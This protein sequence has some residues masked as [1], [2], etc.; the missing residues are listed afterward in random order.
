MND[1]VN[2]KDENSP[3][4]RPRP[5]PKGEAS[6]KSNVVEKNHPLKQRKKHSQNL[7][8]KAKEKS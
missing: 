5:T 3:T 6:K 4:L 8:L 2:G 7:R 1:E